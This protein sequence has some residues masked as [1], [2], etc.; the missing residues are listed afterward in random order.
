MVRIRVYL[1]ESAVLDRGD[2]AA[3][4]RAHGAVGADMLGRAGQEP[5]WTSKVVIF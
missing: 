5:A 3:A 4:R 2:D 1:G